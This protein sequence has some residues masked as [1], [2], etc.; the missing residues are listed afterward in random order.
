MQKDIEDNGEPKITRWRVMVSKLDKFI[1]EN[2][3]LELFNELQNIN[4]K[5]FDNE[6][7]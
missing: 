5:I 2:Y 3:E 1:L 6:G 7:I 4:K